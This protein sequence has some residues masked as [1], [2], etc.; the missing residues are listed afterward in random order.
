VLTGLAS[1]KDSAQIDWVLSERSTTML[2]FVHSYFH[3][4]ER[5]WDPIKT[6]VARYYDEVAQSHV[7]QGVELLSRLE[8]KIGGFRGRRVLDFGGGPGHWA[9]A[10]AQ[11]GA[12]VTWHDPSG[13][14][15]SQAK[16]RARRSGVTIAFSLGYLEAAPRVLREPFDLV[17]C[18]LC[19]C[20]GRGDRTLGRV[21]YN[22]VKP[23]GYGYVECPTPAYAPPRNAGRWLQSELNELLWWKIGHPYP[24]HH[25]IAKIVTSYPVSHVELDYT[26]PLFDIVLF[27]K[28]L[29][30]VRP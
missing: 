21:L 18:R 19:W 8:Q 3:R 2:N 16:E 28:A 22:L 7:D 30:L 15:L 24:P 20:Y 23:G 9:V 25:R 17:F 29:A 27:R 13:R 11:R 6:E 1:S 26:S 12:N 5:G 4:V 14:F 10:M